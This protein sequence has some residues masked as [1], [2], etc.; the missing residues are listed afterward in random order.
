MPFFL[1][2]ALFT[3]QRL[4]GLREDGRLLF[5]LH[6]KVRLLGSL[7]ALQPFRGDPCAIFET[8]SA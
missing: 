8:M 1:R 5:A 3:Q 4:S 6:A 2:R 7:D